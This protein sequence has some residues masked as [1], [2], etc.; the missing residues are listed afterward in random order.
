MSGLGSDFDGID[1]VPEQ[2]EDVSTY[3][4]ITQ[5]LLNRGYSSEQI[6]KILGEQRAA[7]AEGGRSLARR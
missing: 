7:R 3:P 6:R 5:V 4:R 1:M 2:L